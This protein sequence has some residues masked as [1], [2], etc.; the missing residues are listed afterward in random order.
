MSALAT[1]TQPSHNLTLV[2]RQDASSFTAHAS[3]S[4]AT[5][6]ARASGN[7]QVYAKHENA[8]CPTYPPT[9]S[10]QVPTISDLCVAAF[11]N[12]HQGNKSCPGDYLIDASKVKGNTIGMCGTTAPGEPCL[13]PGMSLTALRC[14]A[15][16]QSGSVGGSNGA[17]HVS[18]WIA[19]PTSLANQVAEQHVS[20]Y[21]GH[22]PHP[23]HPEARYAYVKTTANL[24]QAV[25]QT[26]HIVG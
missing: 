16:Q 14:D 11:N 22:P 17:T 7:P 4:I 13:P 8:M 3:T 20:C 6:A 2:S 15:A 26:P 10:S 19:V 25:T 23:S 12:Q 5:A 18:S 21:S 9:S 1:A 24:A